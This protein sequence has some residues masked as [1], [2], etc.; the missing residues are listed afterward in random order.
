M[1]LMTRSCVHIWAVKR[2]HYQKR[3][4]PEE[5]GHLPGR[6]SSEYLLDCTV[7]I[8]GFNVASGVLYFSTVFTTQGLNAIIL[9]L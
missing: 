8:I 3:S 5:I 9:C 6:T 4:H 1:V 2:R 7:R